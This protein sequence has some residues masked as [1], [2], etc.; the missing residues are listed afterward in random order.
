MSEMDELYVTLIVTSML[1]DSRI[2]AERVV[3]FNPEIARPARI[4]MLVETVHATS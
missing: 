2:V 1:E 3:G 4:E